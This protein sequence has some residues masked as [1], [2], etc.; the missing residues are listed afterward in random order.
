MYYNF[1][2]DTILSAITLLYTQTMIRTT[3]YAS[4]LVT[5]VTFP[6]DPLQYQLLILTIA[7][8]IILSVPILAHAHSWNAIR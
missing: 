4:D 1:Y 5:I 7:T 8:Y 2:T 6:V 3:T